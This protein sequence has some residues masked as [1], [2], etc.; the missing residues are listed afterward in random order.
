[1]GIIPRTFHQIVTLTNSETDK[2]HLVRCSF[3]EIYNESIHDL[4]SIA[5]KARMEIKESPDK[6]VFVKDLSMNI[7]KT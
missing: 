3:I 2:L 1:M 4:L 5:T 6:G 7:V